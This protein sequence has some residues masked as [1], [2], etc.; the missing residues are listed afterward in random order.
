MRL[1]DHVDRDLYLGMGLGVCAFVG[2][3]VLIGRVLHWLVS[4]CLGGGC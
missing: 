4:W 3:C 2:F 1:L